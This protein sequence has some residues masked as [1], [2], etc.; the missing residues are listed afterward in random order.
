MLFR[1]FAT[2]ALL[3]VFAVYAPITSLQIWDSQLLK[4]TLEIPDA[5]F[6]KA[7]ATALGIPKREYVTQAVEEKLAIGAKESR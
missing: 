4:T 7:K 3:S 5:T 2:L 6:R 1:F